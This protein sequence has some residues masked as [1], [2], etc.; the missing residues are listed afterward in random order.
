MVWYMP[1]S[2]LNQIPPVKTPVRTRSSLL[3]QSQRMREQR[4]AM[5]IDPLLSL[6][7]AQAML[8]NPCYSTLR[9]WVSTG[10]LHAWRAHPT[11]H[12]KIRLSEIE[13]FRS[14]GA[15]EKA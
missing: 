3:Q 12:H 14:Q 7:Q 5:V 15:G 2:N 8:G 11:G 4:E 6:A 1:M 9:R 13:R 10:L